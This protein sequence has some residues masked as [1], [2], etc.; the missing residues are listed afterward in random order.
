[1]QRTAQVATDK[2]LQG[3][4]TS[5]SQLRFRRWAAWLGL[6]LLF[7]GIA[8]ANFQ[9]LTLSVLAPGPLSDPHAQIWQG[10]ARSESC[11]T[12]HPGL[13]EELTLE[14]LA[15]LDTA[16]TPP[17]AIHP[18]MSQ[19]QACANC[20]A[21]ELQNL[22]RGTPHDLELATLKSLSEASKVQHDFKLTAIM[23][24]PA[25][26]P[27]DWQSRSFICS[28]C[29]REHQGAHVSLAAMDKN[30]C[31]ACHQQKFDSFDTN[32][33]QF[34]N[35]PERKTG[36]VA[37]NHRSHQ[38][39][40]FS[41]AGASFDCSR[42]HLEDRRGVTSLVRSTSFEK[43]CASC[44]QNLLSVALA[45]GVVLW[46]LPNVN[47]DELSAVSNHKLDWPDM[48]SYVTDL[49]VQP[50]MRQLVSEQLAT[51]DQGN[52]WKLITEL[53]V[54]KNLGDLNIA[55]PDERLL[56]ERTALAAKAILLD[57]AVT[58]Q[59][60]LEKRLIRGS[61][62]DQTSAYESRIAK[63]LVQG[64]PPELFDAAFRRWFLTKSAP[65]ES[66]K[67]PSMLPSPFAPPDTES[68]LIETPERQTF[69]AF[70]SD[71]DDLLD[72][73]DAEDFNAPG[74]EEKPSSTEIAV[75]DQTNFDARKHLQHG[76]WMIDENRL[77]VVYVPSGHADPWMQ[78][79]AEWLSYRRDR[80]VVDTEFLNQADSI[81]SRCV[82][83]HLTPKV[84]ESH[85]SDLAPLTAAW[86]TSEV[87]PAE[88]KLT[89]FDHQPHLNLPQLQDCTSCHVLNDTLPVAGVFVSS[90]LSP[91]QSRSVID[92]HS[93]FVHMQ[94]SNCVTC[95]NSHSGVQSCTMCHDYHINASPA[96]A[97]RTLP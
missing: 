34:T 60:A 95:H 67:S 20:H 37:F 26:A 93:D 54:T 81:V 97:T 73:A 84:R 79:Y 61:K 76:G 9:R 96:A 2:I 29:H 11:K 72:N 25:E 45:D 23:K 62:D 30:R 31:Q 12:C 63:K 24:S 52:A 35:Y 4:I 68:L 56:V 91:V 88:K 44:H 49:P 6:A 59:G 22:L 53:A 78:A 71:N 74:L 42:C 64:V 55:N 1:M 10:V 47:R 70:E 66:V 40:H 19:S 75:G 92:P 48:A 33:A 89:R 5:Q 38:S 14:Q 32:H 82:E 57:I 27:I 43:A 46:Q 21:A 8:V 77:A 28:D 13:S 39:Q 94:K 41:K 58:G 69:T 90:Q 17:R 65:V 7:M 50:L 83:C 16:S 18:G 15:S 36:S 86:K 51:E 3:R 87:N 80:S 85:P